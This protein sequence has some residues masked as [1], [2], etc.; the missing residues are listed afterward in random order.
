[1]NYLLV[2]AWLFIFSLSLA[3]SKP[4]EK[5]K[6]QRAV[7]P[8]VAEI[9]APEDFH[10]EEPKEIPSPPLELQLP[11]PDEILNDTKSVIE[12]PARFLSAYFATRPETFLMDP[13]NL[14][15]AVD[16]KDRLD[17]LITPTIPLSISLSI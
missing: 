3:E 16:Y 15:S 7:K 8:A 4:R 5:N 10:L 14:L 9:V 6:N 12:I 1:M 11:K 17:F 2:A 13:Q